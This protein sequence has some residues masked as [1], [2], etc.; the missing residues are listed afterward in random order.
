M[1]SQR[2]VAMLLL[3]V[4]VWPEGRQ[5]RPR[6][7]VAAQDEVVAAYGRE[8]ER[9]GAAHVVARERRNLWAAWPLNLL[10]LQLPR[11]QHIKRQD[12]AAATAAAARACCCKKFLIFLFK[13]LTKSASRPRTPASRPLTADRK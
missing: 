5:Q 3:R 1:R 13:H 6:A 8:R 11:L 10:H 7:V 9:E 2:N 4:C 12:E